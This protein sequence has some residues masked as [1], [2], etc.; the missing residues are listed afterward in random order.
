MAE[1]EATAREGRALLLNATAEGAREEARFKV[2]DAI[3]E[4]II[5]SRC[6]VIRTRPAI[7]KQVDKDPN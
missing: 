4:N 6:L 5:D 2:C 3:R 7:E 1:N